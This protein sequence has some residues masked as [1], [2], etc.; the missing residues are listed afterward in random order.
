MDCFSAHPLTAARRDGVGVVEVVYRLKVSEIAVY[1]RE[2]PIARYIA[3][4]RLPPFQVVEPPRADVA[5]PVT[6]FRTSV[7]Q[8]R[9]PVRMLAVWIAVF[10]QVGQAIELAWFE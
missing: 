5:C 9:V 2:R 1:L 4:V 10:I 3:K 8:A 6:G 7:C